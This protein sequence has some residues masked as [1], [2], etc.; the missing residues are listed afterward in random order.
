MKLNKSLSYV[1]TL[2]VGCLTYVGINWIPIAGP[3]IVGVV[4]GYL[5][6]VGPKDGFKTG[7]YSGILGFAVI[8]FLFYRA[9]VFNLDGVGKLT[10]ILIL[11]VFLLWNIV[12][13][14]LAGVGGAVSSMVFHAH[15][16]FGRVFDYAPERSHSKDDVTS[17]LICSNCGMGVSEGS[18]DCPSCGGKIT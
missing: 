6:R 14:L 15:D 11:W 9:H 3:L 12:G 16:F 18:V 10:S 17:Y 8:A 2:L 7:I 13:I 1:L 4:V 5:R